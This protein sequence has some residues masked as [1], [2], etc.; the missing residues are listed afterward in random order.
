[1]CCLFCLPFPRFVTVFKGVFSNINVCFPNY[2]GVTFV[3]TNITRPY[4]RDNFFSVISA[5]YYGHLKCINAAAGV[6]NQSQFYRVLQHFCMVNNIYV[7]GVPG[8]KV[9][10]S[11]FKSRANVE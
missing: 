8:V 7:Q 4:L 5:H 11:E 6:G 9:N 2:C 3:I 10:I 1:M